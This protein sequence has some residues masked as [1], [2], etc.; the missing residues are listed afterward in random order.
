MDPKTFDPKISLDQNFV[1]QNNFE[2]IFLD[3][4]FLDQKI[5]MTHKVFFGPKLVLVQ[6]SLDPKIFLDPKSKICF[7]LKY[8]GT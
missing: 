2:K 4:I 5:F 1:S 7:T 8:F 6:N 3:H